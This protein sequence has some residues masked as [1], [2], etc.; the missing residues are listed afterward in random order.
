MQYDEFITSVGARGVP[1]EEADTLTHATLRVLAERLT[2]GEAH[3]LRAQLPGEL[4]ADLIPP[5]PEA[6]PFGPAEFAQRVARQAKTEEA[7]ARQ[8]MVAVLATTQDAVEP[9]E[10]DDVLAQLGREYAELIGSAR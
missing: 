8:G 2:G 6:E 9:G 1:R 5:T 7:D 10:F 4:Q 3:D